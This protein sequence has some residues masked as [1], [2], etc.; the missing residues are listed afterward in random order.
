M[1][2]VYT[3]IYDDKWLLLII[4]LHKLRAQN[5]DTFSLLVDRRKKIVVVSRFL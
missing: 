1:F 5:A 4:F 2:T 3:K